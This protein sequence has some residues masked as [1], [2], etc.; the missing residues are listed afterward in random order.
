MKTV[1]SE[2]TYGQWWL[3]ARCFDKVYG[4]VFHRQSENK[5]DGSSLA[6]K[7]PALREKRMVD[8][9]AMTIILGPD[10]TFP[11]KMAVEFNRK[12]KERKWFS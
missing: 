4:C 1:F 6:F 8:S 7:T 2:N 11:S 9:T 5:N 12:K 10:Y 3:H